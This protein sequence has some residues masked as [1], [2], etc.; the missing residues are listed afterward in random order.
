MKISF[1]ISPQFL[2]IYSKLSILKTRK[3]T[4]SSVVATWDSLSELSS[5]L[6][7]PSVGQPPTSVTTRPNIRA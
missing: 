4:V 2:R 5:P 3:M 7:V 6:A 1:K